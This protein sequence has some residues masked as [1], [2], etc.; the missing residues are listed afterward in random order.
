[1]ARRT[2]RG[3]GKRAQKIKK[4]LGNAARFVKDKKLISRL[5]SLYAKTGLPHAAE[6]GVASGIAG[7][8]GFGKKRMV[9]R[10]RRGAGL[11]LAG[12]AL[13]LA[14]SGYKGR[15]YCRRRMR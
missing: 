7:S 2:M 13:R 6:V 11:T 3:R 10:R 9:Y 8:L 1:M 12:G 14:G 15:K 5:G 4:W